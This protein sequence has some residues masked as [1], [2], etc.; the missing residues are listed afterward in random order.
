[1]KIII[2]ESQY[3]NFTEEKLREF[4]YGFWDNQKNMEKNQV[5]MICYL[6]FWKLIKKLVMIMI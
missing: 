6:K 1:M 3:Q 4:L 2:T 5:W